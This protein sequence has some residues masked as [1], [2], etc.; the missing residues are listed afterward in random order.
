M[1]RDLGID[2]T[3]IKKLMIEIAS[4]LK[5]EEYNYRRILDVLGN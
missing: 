3:Q 5:A 4:P 1:R 2:D